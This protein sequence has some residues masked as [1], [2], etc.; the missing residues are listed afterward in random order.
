MS[1]V[2]PGEAMRSTPSKS[3]MK[4]HAIPIGLIIV[5]TAV[6]F[7]VLSPFTPLMAN[8]LPEGGI[9]DGSAARFGLFLNVLSGVLVVAVATA[10]IYL[11]WMS[12]Q[13]E[14]YS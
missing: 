8:I 6:F 10:L 9:D 7:F 1:D 13:S 3:F 2:P 4:Q 12:A 14:E 11:H 5:G